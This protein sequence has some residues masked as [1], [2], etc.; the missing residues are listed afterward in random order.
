MTLEAWVRPTALGSDWRT[1]LMKEQPGDYVYALYA[2]TR[3]H[4]GAQRRTSSSAAYR[5]AARHRAARAQHVDAPRDT[6]DGTT[7]QALRQRRPGRQLLVT[8][9]I[10]TS[11]GALRI[12]GNNIWAE[13]FQ[14][15]TSTRCA[16]TTARCTATEIQ[17]DMNTSISAPDA[18]AAE[19]PGHA[20][21]DRRPR[22][23]RARLGRRDRQRRGRPLQRPPLDHARLHADGRATGSRSRPARATRTPA[24]PPAPTTT[25]SPPRIAAGNVGP[26]EQ[27]GERG[28]HRRHDPA[29]RLGHGAG[30]GADRDRHGHGH[31]ERLRQRR[32]RG[33]AVQARRREPRRRGH[34]RAVLASPGTRSR[35]RT[36]RTRSR[37]SHATRP[38]TRRRRSQRRA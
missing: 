38:A 9:S 27:R 23:G 16:S 11:T 37:P 29:H 22:P 2:R 35:R 8:G 6:Y 25:R 20:H 31:R 4:E 1:A 7:L 13:W 14:G 12:G 3:R 15:L 17:A 28:R 5:I 36:G 21:R 34:G 30:A 24:S 33:R 19:R 10:P 26:A 32:G 18:T